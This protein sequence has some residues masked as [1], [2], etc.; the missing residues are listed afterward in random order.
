MCLSKAEKETDKWNVNKN[1]HFVKH[2]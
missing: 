1:S 2:I